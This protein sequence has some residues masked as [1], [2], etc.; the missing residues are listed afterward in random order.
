MC[1]RTKDG[2]A[3][4]HGCGKYSFFSFIGNISVVW[5][6]RHRT[7]VDSSPA[8][9]HHRTLSTTD[10]RHAPQR[11]PLD[12]SPACSAA[13]LHVRPIKSPL[14]LSPLP[15]IPSATTASSKFFISK[16]LLLPCCSEP[17]APPCSPAV[18]L[19]TPFHGRRPSCLLVP[20]P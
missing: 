12:V 4:K 2:Q 17:R 10:C 1:G 19:A 9:P 16:W 6:L 8:R 15:H 14:L 18:P 7:L 13:A 3:S 20:A 5:P 11:L